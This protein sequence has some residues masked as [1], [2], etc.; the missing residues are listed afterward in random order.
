MSSVRPA[1]QV[2]FSRSA[3]R[4]GVVL[5]CFFALSLLAAKTLRIETDFTAFLPPSA[6]PEQRLL[7]AQ[8]R[9]GLV[10]RLMLVALHGADEKTLAQASRGL[11]QKL[12]RTS[13]F[14]YAAN[15]SLDQF[16]AQ[17]EVLMRQ[18]YVLS[19]EVDAKKFSAPRLR[20]ALEEQ[21][22]QLASPL[23]VLSKAI[24]VRD[25]TGEFLATLRQLDPGTMP[26]LR[27]GVWFSADGKRALL[28]AQT[29]APGF[30][31]VRQA[32]A[33]AQ[34]RGAL[35]E[36][37]PRVQVS[38][39]GPGVFAAESHRLIER[40]AWR[41]SV[42]SATVIL[43]MLVFI[44][45][46]PLP[47]LL[48]LTPVAFGLLSGV[49][50]VQ[51]LFGSVHGITLGFA[52]TLIGE[53]VDY[54]NY[55]LLNTAPGET[56]RSAA[57]RIGVTLALAVL[58]TVASA[59]ALTLSSFKG[60]A[61]LGVLTM[62]GITVAGLVTHRLIPWLLGERTLEFRRLHVP[63]NAALAH[64]RWPGMIAL[65]AT[66]CG[67][68]WLAY[69]HPAWWEHDLANI[70]PVPAE[71]RD[72]DASLRREMGAP[73]VSV[74]VAS[75]GA[76]ETA[77]LQA[78]EEILP[79][80]QQWRQE[81]WIRS[82]DSP[83][84]YLPAPATQASRQRALP[85]TPTL[86]NNL[87][88]AMRGL[89]FRSDV[90]GPFV[91]E[92]VAARTQPLL[93]RAAYAGTPLGAK[94]NALIVELDGQWLV[95]TPL[96][97]VSDSGKLA[98]ALSVIPQ[99]K[100]QLVDLKQ[101]SSE[102]VDGYRQQA[103]QQAAWGA[104]LI[105]LLLMAGLRSLR[106][107]WHV[108]APAAAA[109]VLTVTLLVASG[110]HIS[111]FHLVALLLVLGIGLNYALFFERPAAD[112]AERDRTR[113]SLAVCSISTVATFGFLALSATPVLH[114]IGSTVALGA[115]L[116]LGL[117]AIWAQPHESATYTN[118]LAKA[119]S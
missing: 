18:R 10:S 4:Y 25:P 79:L 66:L 42:C 34:L 81:N 47:V 85:D 68:L 72:L 35:A 7:I 37:N 107:T 119:D 77:A 87:R 41:L 94:L 36:V 109:L 21:L 33:I 39:T 98:A 58:T 96:G 75:R 108:A 54:P 1:W 102:M 60:L 30:D 71:M 5:I 64:A 20:A 16:V 117:A 74:F 63:A 89:A 83:A 95:L 65:I 9:D 69:G 82:Y 99:G 19:P 53:A 55:L 101:I 11:A 26:A 78:A 49:L 118:A 104:I 45:R 24:L 84:R 40:D 22:A 44:Y 48:V 8:L 86:Q 97:G 23:G 113:L 15:G 57:R 61:Q 3:A 67:A 29:R 32:V 13:E 110:Q 12:G 28:I 116:S 56:A 51:A 103:M 114:A 92:V 50:V 115:L 59:L 6:T 112:T 111:V 88:E 73:E 31:S 46:S 100:S 2:F 91:Q 105:L 52:A 70:S 14:D 27:Q 93:T 43:V 106:R 17:S 38:L 90:F 62:I 76:N 80:L